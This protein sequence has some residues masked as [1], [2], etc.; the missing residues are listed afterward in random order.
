MVFPINDK[1]FLFSFSIKN[2][3]LGKKNNFIDNSG[4]FSNLDKFYRYIFKKVV[5][6]QQSY[7]FFN[8]INRRK[9]Q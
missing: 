4:I 3:K 1:L 9:V 6:W 7:L 8:F 5:A 2:A